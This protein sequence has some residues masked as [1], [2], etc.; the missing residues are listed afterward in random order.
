MIR[1]LSLATLLV[2]SVAIAGDSG[3]PPAAGPAAEL[4]TRLEAITSKSTH[5]PADTPRFAFTGNL[6]LEHPKSL[7]EATMGFPDIAKVDASKT[8]V[9]SV[10]PDTA[11]ISTH[12]G[13]YASCGKD[14]CK[15]PDSYLRATAVFEKGASGWQP[16]AWSITPSIPSS[17]QQDAIDDNISPD[18]LTR[19]VTGAED[20]VH[21]FEATIADP[22]TFA[23]T[24]SDRK[25]ILMFGSE[26]PERFAGAKAKTQLSSWNFAFS[27]RDG[28]RAGVSKSGNVAWVAANVDAKPAKQKNA[29]PLPFRVFAVYEKIATTWKLVQL[30]FSTAV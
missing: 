2:G 24:F 18:K 29:K 25:E 4:T 16:L 8:V 6:S 23:G 22:K 13:E 26:M 3:P 19:D 30:Q 7:D 21:V 5:A 17:S 10:D 12:L 28:V 15:T 1:A 20:A 9:I 11:V 14:G 27:V